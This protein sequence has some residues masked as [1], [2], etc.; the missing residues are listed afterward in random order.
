M[1]LLRNKKILLLVGIILFIGI[2]TIFSLIQKRQQETPSTAFPTPTPVQTRR[3]GLPSISASSYEFSPFQKTVIGNTTEQAVVSTIKIST[4]E[5]LPD[6]STKYQMPSVNP[7][8]PDEI[9]SKNGVV[10]YEKT[11]TFTNADGGFPSM[12]SFAQVFGKP[13]EEIQGSAFYGPFAKTY[14]YAT[15]GFALIANPNTD[16]VYEV[17]RFLPQSAASYKSVYGKDINPTPPGPE[18]KD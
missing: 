7:L 1:S 18:L 11:S 8:Q 13:D 16:E 5:V 10:V 17:Q 6:G 12:A 2:T 4:K 3:P 14:I 9:I 15:K